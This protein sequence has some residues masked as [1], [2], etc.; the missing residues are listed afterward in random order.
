VTSDTIAD[1]R[2]RAIPGYRRWL[3]LVLAFVAGYAA[4]LLVASIFYLP[5][6]FGPMPLALFFLATPVTFPLLA[7]VKALLARRRNRPHPLPDSGVIILM[8]LAEVVLVLLGAAAFYL[9][10][11]RLPAIRSMMDI[12]GHIA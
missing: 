6:S 5:L 4:P 11:M 10:A 9:S 1:D 3:W 2:R 8:A 7:T 12:G